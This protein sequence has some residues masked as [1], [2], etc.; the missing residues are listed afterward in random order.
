MLCLCI[1]CFALL[2]GRRFAR[3]RADA[4]G[5]VSGSIRGG[6]AG[7]TRRPLASTNPLTG[8]QG[9]SISRIMA[10]GV[11]SES[12]R[13]HVR[14]HG[15]HCA[16]TAGPSPSL[17]SRGSPVEKTNPDCHKAAGAQRLRRVETGVPGRPSRGSTASP[18]GV[19]LVEGADTPCWY[20]LQ[21]EPILL[22]DS[23]CK[24][25]MIQTL[26]KKVLFRG[27]RRCPT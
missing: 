20:P 16:P 4:R 14:P 21:N 8:I 7:G 5:S 17:A 6:L 3:P 10:A 12:G 9:T 11:P 19:R 18:A 23:Y 26:P 15:L 22:Q 27:R 25:V 2:A 13:K 1:A 24:H